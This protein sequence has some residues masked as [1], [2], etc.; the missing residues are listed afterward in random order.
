MD[1]LN[2]RKFA[3]ATGLTSVVIYLGCFLTMMV[4]GKNSLVK[5]SN[6]LFH[7]M[8]FTNIIRTEIPFIETLLGAVVSFIFWAIAGYILALIHNKM[9]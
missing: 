2:K 9:K 5:L 8:D 1:K 4:L 7:G 3:V 6:L